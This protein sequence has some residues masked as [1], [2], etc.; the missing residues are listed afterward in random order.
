LICL[1][2]ILARIRAVACMRAIT[3]LSSAS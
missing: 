1:A 2:S 3:V